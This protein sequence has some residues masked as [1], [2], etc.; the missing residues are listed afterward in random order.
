[1][2]EIQLAQIA[3]TIPAYESENISGQ[4]EISFENINA[5]IMRDGKSTHDLPYPSHAG[6]DKKHEDTTPHHRL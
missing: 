1:M 6:E 2:F 3:T 4:P 5:V